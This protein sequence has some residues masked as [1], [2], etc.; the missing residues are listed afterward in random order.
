[1]MQQCRAVVFA[2]A[3]LLAAISAHAFESDVHYGLT[4]W[5]AVQAGFTAAQAQAIAT[6]NQRVDSCDIQFIETV[7]AYACGGRDPTAAASV[8]LHHFPSAT[9]VP[10]PAERRTVVPGNEAAWKPFEELLRLGTGKEGLLLYKLGEAL[11]ALQ[12][13]WSNQGVPTVPSLFEGALPCAGDLAWAAS[14]ARGGARSHRPDQTAEWPADTLA[15]AEASYRALTRYPAIAGVKRTPRPWHEVATSLA[16]FARAATKAAKAHWFQEHGV[17]DVSFVTMLSLPDGGPLALGE[18]TGRRL[19]PLASIESRQNGVEP[20][21]LKFANE[22]FEK[23][24]GSDD[25]QATA[26]AFGS[27][28]QSAEKSTAAAR[29][30]LRDLATRL[31]LWRLRDHGAAAALAHAQQPLSPAQLKQSAALAAKPNAYAREE[32]AAD[33]VLSM[34]PHVAEPMPIVPF[35]LQPLSGARDLVQRAAATVKFRNAPYDTVVVL[36]ERRASRWRVMALDALVE[37]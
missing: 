30:H 16:A 36:F 3:T 9:A 18:W 7:S 21:L 4:R 17:D 8:E 33:A 34:L 15:M 37:H 31:Q 20:A 5:L 19:P 6:G 24:I 10:A 26:V 2:A 1:M 11:H 25:F 12:D 28:S 14:A 23:W 29:A 35:V 27:D 13:S 32:S 22:F